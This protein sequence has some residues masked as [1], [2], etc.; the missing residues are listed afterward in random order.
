[1]LDHIGAQVI[2]H[3]IGI[4]VHAGEEILHAIGT[5]IA[6]GFRQMPAVLALERREQALQIGPGAPT[7]F[8]AAETGSNARAEF[9]QL[10]GPAVG[11]ACVR[12]GA[13]PPCPRQRTNPA[14]VLE[15]YSD[16][17]QSR[18]DKVLPCVWFT[19]S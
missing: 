3:R 9:V 1:M 18:K 11:L 13:T 10:I 19:W 4:P 5:G 7:R 2:A 16:F 15:R 8:D 12:H 17:V 6:G 14:V